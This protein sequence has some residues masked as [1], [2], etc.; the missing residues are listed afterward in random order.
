MKL[1]FDDP[2]FDG[3][4]QRTVAKDSF[5]MANAGECLAIAAK[6]FDGD[7]SSWYPAFAG[8][9][10]SLRA[11]ADRVPI[12]TIR[13]CAL[14]T[15]PIGRASAPPCHC[16][17]FRS[18]LR[19]VEAEHVVPPL[20]SCGEGRIAFL[21]GPIVAA[22]HDHGGTRA[23][24]SSGRAKYP[25]NVASAKRTSGPPAAAT[26]SAPAS[27]YLRACEYYRNAFFYIRSNR[28]I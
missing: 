20:H 10:E 26:G 21:G 7:A 19:S 1:V 27:S 14:A 6:I 18:M 24:E 2:D 9:A 8:A 12:S 25:V 16:W 23:A 28:L 3:Q 11:N 22:G 15:P 17:S 4:L 13:S 5:G